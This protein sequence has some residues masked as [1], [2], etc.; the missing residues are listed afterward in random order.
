M[1]EQ[2]SSRWNRAERQGGEQA[3]RPA[4][5]N[6]PRTGGRLAGLRVHNEASQGILGGTPTAWVILQPI[7]A[8]LLVAVQ[9]SPHNLFATGV[10]LG[11]L[12]H[13]VAPI[14][15]QHHLRAQGHAAHSLSADPLEVLP[16]FLVQ[17]HVQHTPCLLRAEAARTMPN[18]WSCA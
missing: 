3:D 9:P 13:A 16:L 18:F 10:D 11:D 14:R 12:G 2:E 15:E 4:S 6:M 17:V 7:H 1:L 8:A 5:L